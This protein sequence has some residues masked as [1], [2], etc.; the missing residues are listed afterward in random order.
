M[1]AIP[2]TDRDMRLDSDPGQ[3]NA[4][5]TRFQI[6]GGPKTCTISDGKE[7]FG[8]ISLSG[9]PHRGRRI[10]AQF[11]LTPRDPGDARPPPLDFGYGSIERFQRFFFPAAR[12]RLPV[13]GAAT[14]PL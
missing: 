13:T 5:L 10:H 2:M 9:P 8:I 12:Q 7:L 11:F 14:P 3:G 6:N 1:P 4:A